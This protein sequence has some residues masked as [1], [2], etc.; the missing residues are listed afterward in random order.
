MNKPDPAPLAGRMRTEEAGHDGMR[1][2]GSYAVNS[3]LTFAAHLR[4][5]PRAPGGQEVLDLSG[6]VSEH[7]RY[8]RQY[9]YLDTFS[10]GGF[11]EQSVNH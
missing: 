4:S 1:N 3:R 8:S 7:L 9:R 6:I 5:R 2:D 11:N 10:T